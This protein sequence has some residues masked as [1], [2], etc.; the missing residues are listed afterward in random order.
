MSVPLVSSSNCTCSPPMLLLHVLLRLHTDQNT[1]LASARLETFPVTHKSLRSSLPTGACLFDPYLSAE[2]SS[3]LL[4]H[5]KP[6]LILGRDI[7]GQS[8]LIWRAPAALLPPQAA[9]CAKGDKADPKL[10][11]PP[12]SLL[13]TVLATQS[14]PS[15]SIGPDGAPR[16]ARLSHGK[17]GTTRSSPSRGAKRPSLPPLMR[18]NKVVAPARRPCWPRPLKATHRR[19]PRHLPNHPRQTGLCRGRGLACPT[20]LPSPH[21][22]CRV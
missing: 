14:L 4:S 8:A 16:L 12:V 22:S 9:N 3:R 1:S 21:T 13:G 20:R 5:Q 2:R 7:S 6:V 19:L 17:R 10:H 18:R 15:R 11:L